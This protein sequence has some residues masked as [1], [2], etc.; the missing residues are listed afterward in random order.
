MTKI[1][2]EIIMQGHGIPLESCV[3]MDSFEA[4][5]HER[6]FIERRLTEAIDALQELKEYLQACDNP[7]WIKVQLAIEKAKQP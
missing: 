6:D 7:R 2:P 3:S 1:K 5:C 4:I